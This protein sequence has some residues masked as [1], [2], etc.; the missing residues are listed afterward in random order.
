[1]HKELRFDF[2]SQRETLNRV[3]LTQMLS[4]PLWGALPT[5]GESLE[6]CRS[7]RKRLRGRTKLS[8]P[9][10]RKLESWASE[11]SNTIILIDT[12]RAAVSKT[13][14]VDLIDLILNSRLPVIWALRYAD[15][16]NQQ[17]TTTD[18]MRML[19]MQA[20]Q[21]GAK[22]LFDTAFPVTA[23]QLREA[24]SLDDWVDI[25][26]RLLS[27]VNQPFI[28]LDADLL[29]HVTMHER[30]EILENLETL[31]LNLTGKVKIV[32]A[33]SSV[34]RAYTD[35]L[36]RLNACLYLRTEIAG[37]ERRLWRQRRPLVRYRR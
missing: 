37:D 3:H 5:S 34:N 29:T 7:I 1:M 10:I 12:L 13:F 33:M 18:L 23:E 16:W 24:N 20:I 22:N 15:Y 27:A 31:R 36:R 32:I 6:F 35:E 25:L 8:L 14:M 26:N 28:A 30:G 9:D 4:Q 19:V 17:I 21:V 2:N 11:R